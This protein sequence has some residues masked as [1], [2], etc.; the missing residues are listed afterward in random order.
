MN[1]FILIKL[2]I[3]LNVLFIGLKSRLTT[4]HLYTSALEVWYSHFEQGFRERALK[5][6]KKS[7]NDSGIQEADRVGQEELAHLLLLL[8]SDGLSK[9]IEYK[10]R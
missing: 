10:D 8:F 7:R 4:A 9:P 2:T 3:Q 5:K 6:K 1:L